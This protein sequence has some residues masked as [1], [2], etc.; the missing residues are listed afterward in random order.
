MILLQNMSFLKRVIVQVFWTIPK[1]RNSLGLDFG[2]HFPPNLSIKM[3][4]V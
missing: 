1:I 4:L 3:F 2:A